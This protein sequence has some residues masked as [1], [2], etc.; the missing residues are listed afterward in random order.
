MP[1][2]YET[3]RRNKGISPNTVI[4]E[5]R[6]I[7]ALLAFINKKYKT[8][9]EP[10]DIRPIDI[11]DFLDNERNKG[12]KDSTVNR[13]LGYVKQWYNYM[14]EI[15]KIQVDFM[16]KLK[17]AEKLDTTPSKI[18]VD[19]NRLLSIKKPLL[20]DSNLTPITKQFFMLVMKGV[21]IRDIIQ[22]KIDDF[23]DKGNY[24]NLY[25]TIQSGK[26]LILEFKD[27]DEIKVILTGIENAIFRN[28]PYFFSSKVNEKYTIFQLG[29]LKN[30][31]EYLTDYIGEPFRSEEVRYAYIHYLYTIKELKIEQIADRLGMEFLTI[32]KTLHKSLERIQVVDYNRKQDVT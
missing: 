4:H 24:F 8:D 16:P 31:L 29:S 21:R 23:E 9:V 14:W 3:Y 2:G 11:K 22:I 12:L 28:T 13:K 30:I 26:K 5:V 18:T 25:L 17:Y 20:N 7:R 27:S 1:Y 15:G 6:M 19:Y 10:R 32:S